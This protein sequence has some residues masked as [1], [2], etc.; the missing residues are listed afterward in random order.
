MEG[1]CFSTILMCNTEDMVRPEE[2]PLKYQN[3]VR[4]MW[5]L[6]DTILKGALRNILGLFCHQSESADVCTHSHRK[7]CRFY[8][9]NCSA[10]LRALNLFSS[11]FAFVFASTCKCAEALMS[12]VEFKEQIQKKTP[13]IGLDCAHVRELSL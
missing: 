7:Y 8:F 2:E 13:Y 4:A 3:D 6:S 1:V 9:L 12:Y 10:C 11:N 5:K